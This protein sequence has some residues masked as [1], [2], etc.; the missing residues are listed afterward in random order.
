[1][2]AGNSVKFSS[3]LCCEGIDSKTFPLYCLQQKQ[4]IET[5]NKM[6][7]KNRIYFNLALYISWKKWHQMMP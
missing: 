4:N 5:L 3:N 1:M 2:L 7:R 6:K